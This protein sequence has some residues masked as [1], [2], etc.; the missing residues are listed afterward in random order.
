MEDFF[1]KKYLNP[2]TDFGFKKLFFNELNKELLIDFLNEI[3]LEEG[4]I[5]DIQYQPTLQLGESENDRKVIFDIFCTNEK[6]EFFIVEMQ[7]AKQPHFRD[8]CLFY[9]SFPIQKQAPQGSWNFDL[10]AVYTVA[11][12][13]F[14]I[15]DEFE[16]DKNYYIEQ[17]HLFRERTKTQYSKKLNFIFVEL[18]KFRK[19]AEELTTNTD[20]WLFSLR[21]LEKLDNRPAEVRGRVFEMLFKA[22]EIKLL[23]PHEMKEYKKS[24]LDY[25]DVRDAA[26]CAREEGREEGIKSKSIE[27]A[28]KCLCK[29]MPLKEIEELTGLSPEQ[30]KVLE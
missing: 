28:R 9:A 29:G 12:L 23:T 21:N 10:K 8:R 24:I 16:D 18:P 2:L 7:K 5:T 15:F 3:I 22:A 4:K 13:D 14:V 26:E 20:R 19:E 25:Q 30:I 11:I 1:L 17:V 6:G 27:I